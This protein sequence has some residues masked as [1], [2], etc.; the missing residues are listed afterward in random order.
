VPGRAPEGVEADPE[1]HLRLLKH[2]RHRATWRST[3]STTCRWM[4]VASAASVLPPFHIV[5]CALR[6]RMKI[7][8]RE[9]IDVRQLCDLPLLLLHRSK[10]TRTAF[11]A[12]CQIAASGRTSSPKAQRRA[13]CC[14]S[15]RPGTGVAVVPSILQRDFGKLRSARDRTRAIRSPSSSR[16]YGIACGPSQQH[17]QEFLRVAGRA[18]AAPQFPT[19]RRAER[20]QSSAS[21]AACG[22]SVG[23]SITRALR[24]RRS[25]VGRAPRHVLRQHTPATETLTMV[26][27][28]RCLWIARSG[29]STLGRALVAFGCRAYRLLED[30]GDLVVRKIGRKQA[31][32]P[33]PGEGGGGGRR[34]PFGDH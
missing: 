10:P 33:G 16:C 2:R 20:W 25:G 18:P 4:T 24:H 34:P 7:A 19:V 29:R 23:T 3:S 15:Q 5:R 1:D 28:R 21:R 27:V 30:E 17:V 13:C 12:L 26:A 14:N 31:D 6:A 32:E 9:T 11:D 8:E 22:R